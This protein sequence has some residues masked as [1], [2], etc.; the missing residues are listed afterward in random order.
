MAR[1]YL[2][3]RKLKLD[4]SP[5]ATR[6]MMAASLAGSTPACKP[7]LGSG[8]ESGREADPAPKAELS[9]TRVAIS[10]GTPSAPEGCAICTLS[11][12]VSALDFPLAAPLFGG[13]GRAPDDR[14]AK[15]VSPEFPTP[16]PLSPAPANSTPPRPETGSSAASPSGGK[17][18]A[19]RIDLALQLIVGRGPALTPIESKELA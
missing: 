2:A 14:A 9:S 12:A 5:A 1:W 18:A 15:C 8:L 10:S 3:T 19:W 4:S 6:S 16:E 7:A 17:S 13:P 11:C